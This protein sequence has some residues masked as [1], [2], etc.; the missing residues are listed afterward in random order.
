MVILNNDNTIE[1]WGNDEF[2]SVSLNYNHLFTNI[3]SITQGRNYYKGQYK[4][5]NNIFTPEEITS[6]DQEEI[7]II[8]RF[9]GH[10]IW[11]VNSNDST[12]ENEISK[13]I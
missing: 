9:I 7:V 11:N 2:T 12:I 5:I 13:I 3:S 8:K 10:I 4:Y 6:I 1:S